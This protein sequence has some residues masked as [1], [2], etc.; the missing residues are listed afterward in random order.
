MT[1]KTTIIDLSNQDIN[2][3]PE[4]VILDKGEEVELRLTGVLSGED[5]NNYPYL[6]FFYDIPDQPEVD[7]ISDFVGLP[8]PNREARDNIKAKRRL[9]AIGDALDIDWS[10]SLNVDE[11]K[12]KRTFAILGLNKE[13]TQ[14]TIAEYV[15]R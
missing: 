3:V 9:K 13:K 12:G 11:L 5:K 10:T 6:M 2:S 14:N 7:E 1:E 4:A 15:S 8:H